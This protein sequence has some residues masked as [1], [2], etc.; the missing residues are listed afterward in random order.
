MPEVV[1]NQR[2]AWQINGGKIHQG[3]PPAHKVPETTNH[4][5]LG[6]Y[7]GE[8]FLCTCSVPTRFSRHPLLKPWPEKVCCTRWT[9]GLTWCSLSYL[10]ILKKLVILKFQK[11]KTAL[12]IP[13]HISEDLDLAALLRK[14]GSHGLRRKGVS[15][16]HFLIFSKCKTLG[17]KF[18]S[19][20]QK[21]LS[22]ITSQTGC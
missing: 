2:E 8:V 21:G 4:C 12:V 13:E 5:R 19:C 6:K 16:W 15:F 18:C 20:M 17:W 14:K 10:L 11:E 9:F 1:W 22:K 3:P 7:I